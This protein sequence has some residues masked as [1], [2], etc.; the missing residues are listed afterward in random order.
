MALM[1]LARI[2]RKM[3]EQLTESRKH[4]QKNQRAQKNQEAQK[5]KLEWQRRK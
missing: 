3:L 1:Y 2:T 5:V 4:T